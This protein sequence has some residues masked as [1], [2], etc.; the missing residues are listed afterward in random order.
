MAVPN[1]QATFWCAAAICAALLMMAAIALG[2]LCISSKR[3]CLH[4]RAGCGSIPAHAAI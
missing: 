2:N 4:M 1:K 3:M